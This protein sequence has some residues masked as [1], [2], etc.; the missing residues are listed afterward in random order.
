[1]RMRGSRKRASPSSLFGF[2]VQGGPRGGSLRNSGS[3]RW[4]IRHGEEV[5]GLA[6]RDGKISAWSYARAADCLVQGCPALW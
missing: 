4:V 5:G 1:M 2:S 6:W 3:N